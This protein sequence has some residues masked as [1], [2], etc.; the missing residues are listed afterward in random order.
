MKAKNKT[1]YRIHLEIN[2]N[3]DIILFPDW[4][5][6]NYYINNNF[7]ITKIDMGYGFNFKYIIG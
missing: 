6:I 7:K 4:Y 5:G 3:V 1:K 2:K